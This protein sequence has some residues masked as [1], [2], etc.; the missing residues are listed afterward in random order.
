[1]TVLI[2]GT[3]LAYALNLTM[4]NWLLRNSIPAL[5]VVIPILFRMMGM[6]G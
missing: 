4:L 5:I 1:V 2:V 3:I 6:G